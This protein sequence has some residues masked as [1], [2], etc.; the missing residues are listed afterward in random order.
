MK[1]YLLYMLSFAVAFTLLFV[2]VP[3]AF[4]QDGGFKLPETA[5][6][7][8]QLVLAAFATF[9]ASGYVGSVVTDWVK[10]I[11]WLSPADKDKV[12][13]AGAEILTIILTTAVAVGATY[14]GPLAEWLD[15]SGVWNLLKAA[16]AVGGPS[17]GV[18]W[19]KYQ[20]GKLVKKETAVTVNAGK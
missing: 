18:A 8:L 17:I 3:A 12:S 4:A 16:I 13:G 9:I 10:K 1:K 20:T 15:T 11:P 2:V 14:A 19:L 7:G 6:E 5:A